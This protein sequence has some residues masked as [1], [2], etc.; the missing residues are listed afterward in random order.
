[1]EKKVPKC[2]FVHVTEYI[3]RL[4]VPLPNRLQEIHAARTQTWL[5]LTTLPPPLLQCPCFSPHSWGVPCSSPHHLAQSHPASLYPA[6][7]SETESQ[8]SSKTQC[9]KIWEAA[10]RGEASRR[11]P[12]LFLHSTLLQGKFESKPLQHIRLFWQEKSFSCLNVSNG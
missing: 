3:N 4:I 12:R 6:H 11:T 10:R 5:C 8:L 7:N 1:M 9:Y 2:P